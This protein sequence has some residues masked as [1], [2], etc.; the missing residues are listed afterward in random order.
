MPGNP[1]SGHTA[2]N[3]S[4]TVD[5][6]RDG[7]HILSPSFT[8]AYEGIHGNGIIL[9]EDGDASDSDRNN[10]TNLPGACSK[11]DADTVNVKGGHCVIDGVV[12]TFGGGPGATYPLNITNAGNNVRGS[13][14]ALHATTPQE[15]L[16]TI[17]VTPDDGGGSA[18]SN[19][20]YMQG[21]IITKSSASYADGPSAYL[22]D[23]HGGTLGSLSNFQCVVLAVVRADNGASSTGPD[24]INILE[25]NDK[26]HF[27]NGGPFYMHPMETE[28]GTPVDSHTD[29]DALHASGVQDGD[30]T[31]STLG[32]LW[33]GQGTSGA[34][35][36]FFSGKDA[37]GTRFTRA[38]DTM[39]D[40]EVISTSANQTFTH[41]GKRIWIITAGSGLNL[42]PSGTFY[43][44]YTVEVRAITNTVTF[45]STALNQ[46]VAAGR[47]ARFAYTGSA[48]VKVFMVAT[49]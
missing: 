5:G 14:S 15:V 34:Q 2:A 32:G 31:A 22:T 37:G 3:T 25:I 44:G 48:W 36:L 4:D 21:T 40:V 26:R 6:L 24:N 8:N 20:C 17:Y 10:P 7:D 16:Y 23:P 12:Y 33:L 43:E 45:D 19:I 1:L 9:L 11:H 47:Y 41:N 27:L 29:L 18:T 46:A 42:N 49:L 38:V 30:F 13:S 35:S 39:G 28:A